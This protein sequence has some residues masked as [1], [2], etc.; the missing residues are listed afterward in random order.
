MPLPS[1]LRSE[2]H[3]LIPSDRQRRRAG[4]I[5]LGQ[6]LFIMV[7]WSHTRVPGLL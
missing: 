5:S 7:L 4:K 1:W 3:D 2:R 6:M